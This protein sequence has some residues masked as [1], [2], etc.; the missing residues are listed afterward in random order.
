MSKVHACRRGRKTIGNCCPAYFIVRVC[1][2]IEVDFDFDAQDDGIK[3]F[4]R[5]KRKEYNTSY[6]VAFVYVFT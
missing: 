3:N 1:E 4:M 2:R 6:L 5:L